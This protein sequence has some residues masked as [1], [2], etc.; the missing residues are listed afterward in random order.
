M[1]AELD[2]VL[3]PEAL[4]ARAWKLD[5]DEPLRQW[6]RLAALEGGDASSGRQDS[7]GTEVVR[8]QVG[9]RPEPG[10]ITVMEAEL[11]VRLRCICQRCLEPMD[12]DLRASPRLVFGPTAQVAAAAAEA[13]GFEPC[14]LEPG[15]TLRQL[16]EDELLLSFPAFPV[17]GCMEDCGALADRLASLAPEQT[18][19]GSS[20]PFEVLAGLKR[21]D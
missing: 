12:L 9:F 20:S 19:D 18:G 11:A 7:T 3:A 16:L 8:I 6:S 17:H 2:R 13:A 15:V 21:T 10:G 4:A 14:E 1:F 5:A